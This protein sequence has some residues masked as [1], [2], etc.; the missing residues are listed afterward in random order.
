MRVKVH[1]GEDEGKNVHV[2]EGEGKWRCGKA[3]PEQPQNMYR[4]GG[5][6]R[7]RTST[8]RN[9]PGNEVERDNGEGI[10][11]EGERGGN[12]MPTRGW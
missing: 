10:N 12:Q 7:L 8:C 5:G 2:E 4:T 3:R 1:E 6:R 11:G 9:A